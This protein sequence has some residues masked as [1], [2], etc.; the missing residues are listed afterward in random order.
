VAYDWTTWL[1]LLISIF[2]IVN[3]IGAVPISLSLTESQS[4]SRRASTARTTAIAVLVVLSLN[5]WIGQW[6]LQLFGISMPSFQVGGGLLILLMAVSMMHARISGAKH[7]ASEADEAAEQQTVAVVPLAIPLLA[8]PGAISTVIVAGRS[9][10]SSMHKLM[11]CAAIMVVAAVL[12]VILRFGASLG[13]KLGTTGINVLTR[14]MGLV[15]AAVAVEFICNGLIEMFP[16]LTTK[17]T[18]L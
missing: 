8:G 12:W 2:V 13:Q 7:T 6:I 1:K 5:V 17:A 3:P 9:A 14:L 4:A 16:L 18:P 15:L 11:A 10:S